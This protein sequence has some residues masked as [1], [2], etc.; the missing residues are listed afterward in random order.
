MTNNWIHCSWP[1]KLYDQVV[2]FTGKAT[3][4]PQLVYIE[5]G[6]AFC[7][8][9]EFWLLL[10]VFLCSLLTIK[11]P[12]KQSWLQG[13]AQSELQSGNSKSQ[14]KGGIVVRALASHQC[15][16]RSNPGVKAIS[17]LS[18]LLVLSFALRGFL[19]VLKF[20]PLLKKPTLPNSNSMWTHLNE[21]I[22]THKCF[23]GKQITN[24][25]REKNLWCR[26]I[27]K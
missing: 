25:G 2:F 1:W 8:Y 7:S 5:I 6:P 19:Q 23:V 16:P 17:G 3:E 18:L 4:L 13:P 14:S 10:I 11:K 24:Y 21:F 27:T 15:G 12:I 20:S 22:T 26:V 9:A